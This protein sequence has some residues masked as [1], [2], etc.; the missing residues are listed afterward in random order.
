MLKHNL[1]KSLRCIFLI[2]HLHSYLIVIEIIINILIWGWQIHSSLQV[3]LWSCMEP[4]PVSVSQDWDQGAGLTSI[5][6]VYCSSRL[7]I[8]ETTAAWWVDLTPLPKEHRHENVRRE[9]LSVSE[10]ADE[11]Q[12]NSQLYLPFLH[13]FIQKLC[14][15][16]Y[17]ETEEEKKPCEYA[18]ETLCSKVLTRGSSADT[19]SLRCESMETIPMSLWNTSEHSW[20]AR[21]TQKDTH[22]TFGPASWPIAYSRW[23]STTLLPFLNLV[24]KNYLRTNES[25]TTLGVAAR[26]GQGGNDE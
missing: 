3:F 1:F 20:K 17:L 8:L 18:E 22:F 6:L 19:E 26:R 4:Q 25:T 5:A 10:T 16:L 7:S 14:S 2:V 23:P 21:H 15:F 24:N 13:R 12:M 11:P 9:D